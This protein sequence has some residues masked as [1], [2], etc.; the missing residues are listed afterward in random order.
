MTDL[1]FSSVGS[2]SSGGIAFKKNI[3]VQKL[4]D[5]V[6]TMVFRSVFVASSSQAFIRFE[7]NSSC[8][9][10]SSTAVLLTSKPYKCKL[11]GVAFLSG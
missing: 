6:S 1:T 3:I 10:T 5:S 7:S 11:L 9:F 8:F 4:I 2:M